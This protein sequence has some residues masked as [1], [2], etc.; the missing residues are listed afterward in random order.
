MYIYI[1][2]SQHKYI[3]SSVSSSKCLQVATRHLLLWT[4]RN[5]MRIGMDV[6]GIAKIPKYMGLPIHNIRD[7]RI[8]PIYLVLQPIYCLNNIANP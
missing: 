5:A 1:H 7:F 6:Y 4:P 2:I 3:Y 8:N